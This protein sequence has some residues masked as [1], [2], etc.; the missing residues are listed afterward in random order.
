MRTA[1]GFV[2][3][4]LLALVALPVAA[5]DQVSLFADQVRYETQTGLV[6]AEGNVEVFYQGNQLSADRIVYDT[7]AE[8]VE[9]SGD[10]RLASP[11]GVVI[12][13]SLAELSTDFQSGLI[14]GARLIFEDEFQVASTEGARTEGR[15]NTLYRTVA[16]SCRVCA[17]SEVPIWR[18]RAERVIHDEERERIYFEDA[19]FDVFG[20][21][22]AYL[23]KFRIPAPGVERAEGFLIPQLQTS[24]L[25][26]FGLSVPYFQPL[27]DHAD[28]TFTPFVATGGAAI[29]E[30]E[31]RQE[32]LNGNARLRGIYAPVDG[33]GE[34]NR[35]YGEAA[36]HYNLPRGFE[37]DAFLAAAGDRSFLGQFDYSDADRLFSF[38][39]LNRIVGNQLLDLRIEGTQ[40]LREDELQGEIP[41]VLPNLSYRRIFNG[42]AGQLGLEGGLISLVREDGR[43]VLRADAGADWRGEVTLPLGIRAAGIAEI[44][45]DAYQV[46]DDAEFGTD[47]LARTT[48]TGG[49]EL[50][51]PFARSK[52]GV[53]HVI[54][55]VAQLLYGETM[56]EEDV[57]NEDSVLPELDEGNLFGINRFPGLDRRE[58]GLRLNAGLNYALV[59]P[60]TSVGA[61]VGRVYRSR[62]DPDFPGSSSLL[63][64]ASDWLIA[65][66]LDTNKLTTSARAL[67]DN[68]FEFT[69]AEAEFGYTS[70]PF[71][72]SVAYTLIDGDPDDPVLGIVEERQE[73]SVASRYT[74]LPNWE[75]EGEWRY[76][77]AEDDNVFALGA[78]TYGNEC[79]EAT[80][81]V[82]RRFTSVNEVPEDTRFQLAIRLNGL[83]GASSRDW[84]AGACHGI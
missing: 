11:A 42:T 41:F 12:L 6:V 33:L 74:F 5:Q 24:D 25:F 48:A 19:Y 51:W 15:F 21:P 36:F 60:S 83:G 22:V 27:G 3:G 46:R 75:I 40:T 70:D 34:T 10:I 2:L 72:F 67:F 84:P 44:D 80:F 63:G 76:D 82:S 79:I 16:S 43:D 55:P 31:Y 64:E 13:A 28:I 49:V 78:L 68:E 73:I 56:G 47:L 53:T 7:E 62:D 18:V 69:R 32:F 20:V 57:P 29:L 71:D 26:G 50:R 39:S 59:S 23:P 9:A 54:E 58:T 61:T 81:S 38:V 14:Q 30:A 4:L 1:F 65:A 17:G 37:V 77:I 52:G 45:A 8:T 66:T 35:G